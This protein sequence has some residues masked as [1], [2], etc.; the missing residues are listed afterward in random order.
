M[1]IRTTLIAALFVVGL[2]PLAGFTWFT[3]QRTIDQEFL[4]VRD[5]HLLL[6]RNLSAALTRYEK[7]V[8]AT[9]RAVASSLR[10]TGTAGTARELLK[11]LNIHSVAVIDRHS[12]KVKAFTTNSGRGNLAPEDLGLIS[13]ARSM[14]PGARFKFTPVA[15][16]RG[17]NAMHVVGNSGSDLVVACLGTDYFVK[18]GKQVSFGEKGHAAIVDQ[19]GNVLA[20]PL[21]SW[22]ASAKNI[23]K[24]SAVQR[25]MNGETGVEQFYSPALKG[26]MIAG[27]TSVRGPG[28]GVMIPQPVSE[29]YARAFGNLAPL[30][31]GLC[32]AFVFSFIMMRFALRSLAQPLE[33]LTREFDKQ[34]LQ[35]MPSPVPP[36]RSLTR[37]HELKH[38][39]TAYNRLATTV[40]KSSRQLAEKALQDPV[41]SIGNRTYFVEKSQKQIGQRIALSKKGVL[42]LVDLDGFKDINDTRGHG[43]GDEVLQSFAQNLFS[44]VK[45]FMDREFRGVPGS[46]PI[47]GRIGGDEF[48]I[49]LPI[50]R[51]RDDL[52]EIG[53]KLRQELP[54]TVLVEGIEIPCGTS[55]G[56]AMYPDHGTSVVE[57]IR[58]ADVALYT[59]KADGKNRFTIYRKD[60]VLGGKSEI[61]SAV[62]QAIER[63]ELVLEYQPK[64]CLKK[65]AVTGVEALLRWNHPKIGRVLPNLFLPAVQQTN[66]MVELGEWVTRR[67]IADM[68]KMEGLGFELNVAINIGAEHFS[69][70]RF[71]ERLRESCANAGFDP[72]RLQVEVTEDVMDG[73]RTVFKQTVETLRE[74]G[75]SIAI[76]DFGKGFSNLSRMAAIPADII[77]LDRSLVSEAASQPRV[78]AVMESAINMSHALG[79]SV[80]V[81]GV[82]TIKEATMARQ[83]GADAL[84]GFFFSKSLSL[85]ELGSWLEKQ[86][87]SP[88]HRQMQRLQKRFARRAA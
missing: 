12:G 50:P 25:M 74:Y 36:S 65:N 57:L 73:S 53:E 15:R 69:H 22:I 88:Q 83:A 76:D 42:I 59:S 78:R 46:P 20:H 63:D 87:T 6:A 56:G 5:R 85:D 26:D 11:A 38:I 16:H 47:I 48:A 2:V 18:L 32:I 67:A 23:S 29:L 68:Q 75:F 49:L 52:T 82:E 72:Q 34:M 35:G 45:R 10:Q 13:L 21:A 41:T 64:Y 71:V 39:V 28:W 86:Q 24:V 61:L 60:H 30:L 79:S 40:Q 84:Q 37:I 1:R 58:R 51:D 43:V 7:D 54:K 80:I 4:D 17:S 9:V 62:T 77:K 66:V 14:K 27:L 33:N 3:Y 31:I 81:E 55:A 44:S 19:E 70:Q 8:R